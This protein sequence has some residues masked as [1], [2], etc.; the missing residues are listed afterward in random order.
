[1]TMFAI[2]MLAILITMLLA[3]SR[4]ALGPTVYDRIL[5]LNMFGTKTILLI[6]VAGFLYGRPD[7]LDIALVY[8][9]VNFTGTI[10]VCKYVRYGNLAGDEQRHN[11]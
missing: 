8:G 5:A 6:C 4:A 1:M 7:W 2:T 3:L 11:R 9:L 10:A